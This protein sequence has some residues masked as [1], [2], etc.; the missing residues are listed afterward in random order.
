MSSSRLRGLICAIGG[1]LAWGFS[2][3]CAQFLLASCDMP[4]LVITTIRTL[5][6]GP[7]LLALCALRGTP[8][9]V[10][11]MFGTPRD[12][13]DIL[14]FGLTGIFLAQL[15]YLETIA[16]TNAGTATMLGCLSTIMLLVVVCIAHKRAPRA[17]EVAGIALAIA[18]TWLIATGGDPST[19]AISDIGL[20][21]GF[22]CAATITI[23]TLQSKPL[24]AKWGSMQVVAMGMII[25]GLMC[26]AVA[27]PQWSFPALDLGGWAALAVMVIV[28]TCMS[29]SLFFQAILDLPPVEVGMLSVVEPIAAT[30]FSVVWLGTA[31]TAADYLGFTLMVAMVIIIALA[32]EGE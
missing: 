2:G 16:Y 25:G 23:Y 28:G 13:F 19:L 30:F 8:A 14:F 6:A 32:G 5:T 22:G 31:F 3:T 15:T 17:I 10:R 4:S 26:A 12:A 11:G 27:I 18:A 20:L 24:M 1:C 21:M 7:I 9:N 29:Y